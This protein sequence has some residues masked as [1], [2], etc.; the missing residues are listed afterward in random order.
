[1]FGKLVGIFVLSVALIILVVVLTGCAPGG[2]SGPET[3]FTVQTV[4]VDGRQVTCIV[5]ND[6]RYVGGISCDWQSIGGKG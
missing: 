6:A 4:D 5:W 3:G 2:D 1:M